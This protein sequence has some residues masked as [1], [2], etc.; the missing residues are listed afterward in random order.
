MGSI[1]PVTKA[2]VENA[3]KLASAHDFIQ[4]FPLGYHTKVGEAGTQ[5]SGGQKQ[6]LAIARALIR[7]PAVLL[8]DEA[9]SALDS[10]SE[11]QVQKA[12]DELLDAGGRTTIV[13]AHRLSTVRHAHQICVLDKGKLAEVGTH[14]ELMK[15]K[16]AYEKLLKLQLSVQREE[17]CGTTARDEKV[18]EES[19]GAAEQ[20]LASRT[21]SP[22]ES[23]AETPGEKDYTHAAKTYDFQKDLG[24]RYAVTQCWKLSRQDYKYY[25]MGV[26]FTILGSLVM[27]YYSVQFSYVV[28]IFNQP[29]AVL[30]P[31]TNNWYAAYNEPLIA[32]KVSNLCMLMQALSIFWLLQSI[33]SSWAFG[34]AGELLT[35]REITWHDKQGTGQILWKLGAD[36]PQLKTLVGANIASAAN[37][38]FTTV[39]GIGIAM[40]FSWRFCLCILITMPLLGISSIGVALNMRAIEGDYSSGIVSESVNSVKTVTAF[41]LQ[42]RLLEKYEEKLEEHMTD[43]R[44]IRKLSAL[45]TG[46]ASG[47]VFMIL[48][49]AVWGINVFISRGLMEVDIATIVIM[50]LVTTVSA[51]G[52]LARLVSDTSLPQDA[53]RR[54]FNVIARKSKIDP[55]SSEGLKL[56]EVKGLVEFQEVY[57]RYATRPNLSVMDGLSFRVEPGT[58]T[59]LV[60]PSGCGKSTTVSLIQRFYDPLGPEIGQWSS[61]CLFSCF[62]RWRSLPGWA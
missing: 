34:K 29:P 18:E 46:V 10:A 56:D 2:D 37:F 11:R 45:G 43:E 53:A 35:V 54:I 51:F 40:Y 23:E 60:G 32:S 27:P 22:K 33:G 3:A 5:L 48:A 41:G 59:A 36:I 1:T 47:S 42:P 30:D 62:G 24:A 39:I 38:L 26:G 52:E 20:L 44:G 49:L 8:L 61:A 50:V 55:F 16:G 9:T 28:N 14:D 4:T 25:V 57:F 13:V 21:T 19:T 31:Q 17:D 6:R 7:K 15:K 58:T 12:L